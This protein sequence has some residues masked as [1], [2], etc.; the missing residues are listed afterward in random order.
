MTKSRITAIHC[1]WVT[2]AGAL[3]LFLGC[4][5]RISAQPPP[6]VPP[7]PEIPLPQILERLSGNERSRTRDL[8]HYTSTRTYRLNNQ[9]FGKTAEMTVLLAYRAPGSKAFTVLSESGPRA[10]CH[11][12]LRR[13]I[14]SEAEASTDE[15]RR[16]S[17]LTIDNY[18]FQFVRLDRNQGRPVYVLAALPRSKSKYLMRGEVWVDTADLAI[19]RIAGQAA[20]SP[21]FWIRDSRFVY[22]FE[23]VQ[24]F[25]L[26]VSMQ[27]DAD[28]RV[29]G[30]TEVK[31]EYGDYRINSDAG[32]SAQS[33]CQ[34]PVSKSDGAASLSSGDRPHP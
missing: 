16:L 9:R 5:A 11:L 14:E 22:Q 12:V 7:A 3:L 21:S 30:H 23:K 4:Q 28:A 34:P 10:L 29:F 32:V 25:W 2:C 24:S 20:K 8:K 1:R 15:Q 13:M 6:S 33:N 19:S 18:D 26:P 31:V 27:S 17:Q